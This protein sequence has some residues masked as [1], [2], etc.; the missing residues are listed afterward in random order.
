MTKYV[1]LIRKA[2][3]KRRAAMSNTLLHEL[4]GKGLFPQPTYLTESTR[5]PVWNAA[6]VDEWIKVRLDRR[7]LSTS[8]V[9]A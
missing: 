4:L 2:E 7:S 5:I 9:A 3:V 6:E 8:E 1:E